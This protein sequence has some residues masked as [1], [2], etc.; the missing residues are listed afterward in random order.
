[1]NLLE[2]IKKKIKIWKNLKI[3]KYYF[4]LSFNRIGLTLTNFENNYL[5]VY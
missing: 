3:Y 4:E 2:L 5:K 1:M